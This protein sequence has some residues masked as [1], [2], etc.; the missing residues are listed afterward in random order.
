[1]P[2]AYY[3]KLALGTLEKDGYLSL[4]FHPWEFADLSNYNIPTFIKRK[5]GTELLDKLNRLISDLKN[6][7]EFSTIHSFLL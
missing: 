5:S 7:G 6:E 1:M 4:Y 2:Y 3:K